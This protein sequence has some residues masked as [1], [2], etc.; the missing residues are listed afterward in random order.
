MLCFHVPMKVLKGAVTTG[1]NAICSAIFQ[2]G[3][4]F[5]SAMR[6]RPDRTEKTVN[7]DTTTELI[8]RCIA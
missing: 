3:G 2:R 1:T 7:T 5:N 4:C 6:K 8:K